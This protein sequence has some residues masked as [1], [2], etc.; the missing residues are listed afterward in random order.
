MK[1]LYYDKNGFCLWL[2]R[3]EKDRFPWSKEGYG[4]VIE[5]NLRE[6]ELLLN[7]IDVWK[8]LKILILKKCFS[9]KLICL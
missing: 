1:M 4:S 6:L 2:K 9:I 5:M 8:N 7:G 3:L